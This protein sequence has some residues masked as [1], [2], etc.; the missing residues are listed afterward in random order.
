M[1]NSGV[2]D[3][4]FEAKYALHLHVWDSIVLCMQTKLVWSMGVHEERS[5]GCHEELAMYEVT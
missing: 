1:A 2:E 5:A 4:I 3:A